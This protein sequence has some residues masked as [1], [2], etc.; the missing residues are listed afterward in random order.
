M[1][2]ALRLIRLFMFFGGI[3]LVLLLIAVIAQSK[4][5]NLFLNAD[6]L[7]LPSIYLD[8]FVHGTGIKGWH[9]NASP[10]FFPDMIIQMGLM[11]ILKETALTSLVFSIIQFVAMMVL[12][13]FVVKTWDPEAG[14]ETHIMTGM[15]VL[16]FLVSP[17]LGEDPL[18]A[19]ILLVP[20]YHCGFFLNSLLAMITGMLY[21][22]SGKIPMLIVTGV[23]TMLA[24]LSDRIFLIG[25]VFPLFILML[26]SVIRNFRE[27]RYYV[28]FAVTLVSSLLGMWIFK[29][30]SDGGY[31]VIIG[32]GWKMFN[33]SNMGAS[34]HNLIDHMV[35]IIKERPVQR[36]S[37]ILPLI[38]MLAAPVYLFRYL[39]SYLKDQLKQ[40]HKK[41]FTLILI[42]FVFSI[43][44]FF[45]PV[46][47]GSY[48]G[49]AHIRYNF[50]ALVMG[51]V[52]FVYLLILQLKRF[53]SFH[54]ISGYFI[55]GL[56]LGLVVLIVVAGIA[57]NGPKGIR[58]YV[59]Y[60]PERSQIL[61]RLKDPH[62][63]KYGIAS[64][65]DAK[66]AT[67]FSQNDV[68]VY[69]VHEVDLKPYY[70][71]TNENWYHDGGKGVHA[72][73]VFN[74]IYTYAGSDTNEKLIEVF[75]HQ[76]DTIYAKGEV[77][78]IKLPE[79]KIDR[80]TRRMI[81]IGQVVGD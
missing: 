54:Q 53:S 26:L 43:A 44:I 50:P 35:L 77:M 48:L 15:V 38:F 1:K 70:H 36:W 30:I 8:V 69:S 18:I 34:F 13:Y 59:N 10:N 76:L 5:I 46:I 79:F 61:D 12:I 9:L 32:P 33:F 81:P 29:I 24:V 2:T 3:L 39:G 16:L 11:G 62:G 71:V 60:Y 52:G 28:L 6:T 64:Y 27:H 55:T 42:L 22:R 14:I 51:S 49:P 23:V 74:F 20:A 40:D 47:N 21:L 7:Y 63:L 65:W 17:V 57:Q 75:G 80:T 72:N 31:V 66:H 73:P 41:Q 25:F 68:R 67:I 78:V 4:H 19:F 58:K 56:S 37:V 45:T